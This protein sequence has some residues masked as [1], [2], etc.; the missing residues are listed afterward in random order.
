MIMLVWK[1]GMTLT[2]TWWNGS[3]SK[4][5]IA[6]QYTHPK[7][8]DKSEDVDGTDDGVAEEGSPH[9]DTKDKLGSRFRKGPNQK[10]GQE[11]ATLY[12]GLFWRFNV[13]GK[14]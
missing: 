6:R 14:I 9:E 7:D 2:L 5:D 11:A 3:W 8:E 13:K 4:K 12:K 10:L 1:K